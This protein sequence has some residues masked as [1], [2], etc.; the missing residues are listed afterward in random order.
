[1]NK[2][3][4]N[5]WNIRT[6]YKYVIY[7]TKNSM[8]RITMNKP[9][10]LNAFGWIGR[11]ED[12]QNFWSAL[13]EAKEDDSIKTII[14]RGSDTAFGIG[15]D[16]NVVDVYCARTGESESI[17]VNQA[18]RLKETKAGLHDDELKIL[19]CPKITIAQIDGYCLSGGLAKALACDITIASD[20]ATFGY[21]QMGLVAA[22]AGSPSVIKLIFNVGFARALEILLTG[23]LV[24]GKEAAQIGMISR[25]VPQ[26]ELED[27]VEKTAQALCAHSRD[28]IAISKAHRHLI[29][30]TLGVVAGYSQ[31]YLLYT[32]CSNICLEPGKENLFK[33]RRDMVLKTAGGK[34]DGRFKIDVNRRARKGAKRHGE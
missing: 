18:T 22:G 33:A 17:G 7:E 29:Y 14:I 12:A 13:E 28:A 25:S 21:P 20:T 9:D 24:D 27:A 34:T 30:D 3:Q 11:K 4:A 23:R 31:S 8:A 19:L 15:D 16:H 26:D 2:N 5:E 10:M 32:L 6:D 1:L